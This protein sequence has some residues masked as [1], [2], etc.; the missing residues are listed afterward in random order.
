[1]QHGFELV[2]AE[3]GFICVRHRETQAEFGFLISNGAVASGAV[4][5]PDTLANREARRPAR[6]FAESEAARLG[7]AI[8]YQGTLAED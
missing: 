5:N 4:I 8:A 6:A 7:Y 3:A 1:M 2:D